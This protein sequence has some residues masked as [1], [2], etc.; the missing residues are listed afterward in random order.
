MTKDDKMLKP[1][2]DNILIE[3]INPENKT[4]GGIIIPDNAREKPTTGRVIAIGTDEKIIVKT[5]DVVMFAKWAPSVSEVKIDGRD[6]IIIKEKD[7]LGV[8]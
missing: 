8:L 7:I 5:N 3:P 4:I 1:L 6:L 2:H